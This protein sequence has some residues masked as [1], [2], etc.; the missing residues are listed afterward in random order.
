ML[1]R[2]YGK[3]GNMRKVVDWVVY[4][5]SDGERSG[6]GKLFIQSDKRACHIDLET[7]K[8]MLSNGKGHPGFASCNA[9]TGAVEVDIPEDFLQECL[10][11][12]PKSGDTIGSAGGCT[13]RIA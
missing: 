1:K 4:P 13:V 7:K 2:V 11:A 10:E 9:F 3:L 6:A 12:Q 5:P 8:G